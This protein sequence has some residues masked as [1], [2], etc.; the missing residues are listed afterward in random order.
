MTG[1][2]LFYPTLLNA[3]LTTKAHQE[4]QLRELP[5]QCVSPDIYN[6]S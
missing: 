6:G 1:S 3:I 5:N 4:N 2:L